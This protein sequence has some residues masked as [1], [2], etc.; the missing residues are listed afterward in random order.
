[1]CYPRRV[2]LA[3]QAARFHLTKGYHVPRQESWS[4]N[5]G[6]ALFERTTIDG[7]VH[8]ATYQELSG[9]NYTLTADGWLVNNDNAFDR[10]R[11]G[12]G[13]IAYIRYAQGYGELT[14]QLSTAPRNLFTTETA[15][16]G[17]SGDLSIRMPDGSERIVSVDASDL[18]GPGRHV[19]T[20]TDANGD[21][22]F[23]S[24]VPGSSQAADAE[25]AAGPTWREATADE[26]MTYAVRGYLAN[27]EQELLAEYVGEDG[28]G[29]TDEA[30]QK[31][32]DAAHAI[33]QLGTVSNLS[34]YKSHLVGFGR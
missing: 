9:E 22:A 8:T 21:Q 34:F 17:I 30:R 32:Y 33:A 19:Y 16:Y 27:N 28:L 20:W 26:I 1:M 18:M 14:S 5:P 13:D 2:S 31:R 10:Y 4:F 25:Q 29:M 3:A 12:S 24:F 15:T 23:G 11:Q 6:L 7:V